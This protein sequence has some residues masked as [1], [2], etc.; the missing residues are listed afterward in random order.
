MN[1]KSIIKRIVFGYR[2][3]SQSYIDYLKRIGVKVGEGVIFY[4]PMNTT[5]DIQN[6]HLLEIGNHVML[7]GPVTILTHDYSWSVI[8]YKYGEIIGNQRYTV[9]GNNIFV[10]WG[11]TILA[12]TQIGNNTIIG[13]N[14][15]VSGVLE[16][17]AVYAGNPA[18]KIMSLDEYY[19][20]RK[21]KQLNEA[22]EY[23]RHYHNCF[24][25]YPIMDK[26]DEYFFLYFDSSDDEQK[27]IYDFKLK[28]MGNYAETLSKAKQ[29]KPKFV[30]F[31][32]FIEYCKEQ[33]KGK[34]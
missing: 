12:G 23:V 15:V 13:A 8:K 29:N 6:P 10:G 5:I 20:K 14:S 34:E 16:G 4:R 32:E 1:L 30:S 9:L 2:A 19:N 21:H 33:I 17:D 27:K 31:N 24:G 11:A 18:R 7:T 3:T 22:V 28:L 26:L 25:Q